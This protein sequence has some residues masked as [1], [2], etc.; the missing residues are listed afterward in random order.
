MVH[1]I[2]AAALIAAAF[3]SAPPASALVNRAYASG[4]GS[5]SAS[6]GTIAAP[7]KT[8]QYVHDKVIN[9]GGEIDL[10]GSGEYGPIAITKALT[11]VNKSGGVASVTQPA[12]GQ[13]AM[14]VNAGDA[15]VVFLQGLTVEG[16]WAANA[17]VYFQ[18][19]GT[20]Q[21]S[22][23]VI[24]HFK[25][26][27]VIATSWSATSALIMNNVA[28]SDTSNYGV[29][30]LWSGGALTASVTGLKVSNTTTGLAVSGGVMRGPSAPVVKVWESAVTGTSNGFSAV[31]DTFTN[32]ASLTLD[33][34]DVSGNGT[35]VVATNSAL[36][37]S[38]SLIVGNGVGVAI[39]GGRVV[40]NK[41]NS[42][43][44]NGQNVT[45]GTLTATGSD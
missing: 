4:A 43:Q 10:I 42:I 3:F 15:D 40:S 33:K 29:R 17:G 13:P 18:S 2:R 14:L 9:P 36:H 11:I 25:D 6:C 39:S 44:D 28:I 45:G 37:L 27:G 30:L 38:R 5:D 22:D 16:A 24:R 32:P 41:T 35:G 31:S 19:G 21:I 8:L 23:C 34:V 1:F 20:L 12:S 26:V 7:C